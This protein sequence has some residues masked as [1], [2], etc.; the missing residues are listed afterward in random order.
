MQQLYPAAAKLLRRFPGVIGVGVGYK[1]SNDQLTSQLAWRVYV[2]DK[3]KGD[4]LP[5]SHIIPDQVEGIPTDVIDK[6][7]SQLTF[8]EDYQETLKPGIQ[9]ASDFGEEGTLGCFAR[10][11]T[12]HS[13]VLLSNSHILYGFSNAELDVGQPSVSSS[14][15]CKC[16][17]IARNIGNGSNNF[18]LVTVNVQDAQGSES[19]S[20]SE[21]DCAIARLNGKRPY[22]NEIPFIGMI[23]GTPPPGDFGVSVNDE[24]E[25]VGSTTG[26]T[27]GVILKSPTISQEYDNGTPIPEILIPYPRR[28][29]LDELAGA[30]PTINQLIIMPKP[31][32]SRFAFSGDSGSV[33]VNNQKQVIGLISG[34]VVVDDPIKSLF[35]LPDYVETLGLAN[36][37]HK[38]LEAQNI[39]IPDNLA[40]TTPTSGK[41]LEINP[42]YEEERH[43]QTQVNELRARLNQTASGQVLLNCVAIHQGEVNL[44]VNRKRPVAVVWHRCHGPAFAAHCLKSVRDPDHIIPREIDGV[45]RE[46]II[47]EMANALREYGS[48]SLGEMIAT[49]LPFALEVVS[50]VS[51]IRDLVTFAERSES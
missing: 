19:Y 33:V 3:K 17:V 45:S 40:S 42:L 49:Y 38:V 44:L 24:V 14:W 12:D 25:K 11:K 39:E 26:H 4:R 28:H 29:Y 16:R 32:Y 21:Y 10:L 9:I 13:I 6:A 18:N 31:G 43:F 22:T 48:V 1:E 15:C 46:K 2:R 30:L 8:G 50:T 7:S 41:T 36:P 23:R 51:T 37:I 34:M 35:N 20:G 5:A 27:K 47:S